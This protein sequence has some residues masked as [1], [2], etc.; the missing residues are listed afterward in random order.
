MGRI[1]DTPH[2]NDSESI[3]TLCDGI[4]SST[5]RRHKNKSGTHVEKRVWVPLV[6]PADIL[7]TKTKP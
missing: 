6:S 2:V 5:P 7:A 4:L 3:V 1:G